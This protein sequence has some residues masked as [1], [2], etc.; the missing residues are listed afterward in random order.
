[1]LLLFAIL[2]YQIHVFSLE[3][4]IEIIPLQMLWVDIEW[5]RVT[6]FFMISFLFRLLSM[7][8]QELRSAQASRDM[9]AFLVSK[10]VTRPDLRDKELPMFV[11]HCLQVQKLSSCEML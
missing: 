7:I 3:K 10:L 1:M 5:S 11:D 8:K 2:S 9:A 6:Q 4:H